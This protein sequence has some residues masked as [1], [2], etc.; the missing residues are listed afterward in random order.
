MAAERFVVQE[1][2]GGFV[3]TKKVIVDTETGVQY[4]FVSEGYSGG[5]TVLVGRDGKPLLA[6][7]YRE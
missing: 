4:L 6:R 1:K 3:T 2:E 5:L 7:N